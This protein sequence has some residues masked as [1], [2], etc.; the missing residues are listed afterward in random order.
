MSQDGN[1]GRFSGFSYTAPDGTLTRSRLAAICN[2]VQNNADGS[3]V[4]VIQF[5]AVAS[6]APAQSFSFGVWFLPYDITNNR[7]LA[8]HVN[9]G[10]LN[11]RWSIRVGSSQQILIIFYTPNTDTFSGDI[12]GSQT[13][14][15][16][17]GRPVHVAFT[18]GGS[19]G[20]NQ[21]YIN[22]TLDGSSTVG[23]AIPNSLT[24]G[25]AAA[26]LELFRE[27]NQAT[28]T[29][30]PAF[31]RAWDAA[32]FNRI[33]SAG[34]IANLYASRFDLLGKNADVSVQGLMLW[35]PLD[36]DFSD[37]S[38]QGNH[39]KQL[40]A[41]PQG[42][43]FINAVHGSPS[44]PITASAPPKKVLTMGDS[45]TA[46][47]GYPGGWRPAFM[48][49]MGWKYRKNVQLVGLQVDVNRVVASA[50]SITTNVCTY[51][52]PTGHGVVATNLVST[53]G[54]NTNITS[55][56]VTSVTSTTIVAPVTAANGSNGTGTI[57]VAPELWTDGLH[58]TH[59]GISGQTLAQIQGR[60]AAEL[61][62]G[63]PDAVVIQGGINDV[64]NNFIAAPS[65]IGAILD[66]LYSNGLPATAPVIVLNLET[67][68][69]AAYV[70][71]I[72]AY[73]AALP[74][75]LTNY[76]AT[77]QKNIGLLDINSM[78]TL[79]GDFQTDFIHPNQAGYEKVG[80]A[81]AA[82]LSSMM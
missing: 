39:G 22:G 47:T 53:Y 59:S 68:N 20:S 32:F 33:L 46:G 70:S 43:R 17:Y 58:G 52:V 77:K 12:I 5:P 7:T 40:P 72:N 24:A 64:V 42:P 50:S 2:G 19:L 51:T 56:S 49:E 37:R 54:F 69:T 6:L 31:G 82:K 16:A 26:N 10:G 57:C 63:I 62:A 35:A 73:N 74:S 15:I 21:L 38:G 3:T 44:Y 14:V 27:R 48:S 80:N 71:G 75:C 61:A 8:G 55:V 79:P 29:S 36:G 34:D 28:G 11:A 81:I 60:V 65:S 4:D 13:G 30:I 67:S 9:I 1:R 41:A 23:G 25:A 66:S 78:L 76:A 45:I 18:Y